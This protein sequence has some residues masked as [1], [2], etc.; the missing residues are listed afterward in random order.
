[1]SDVSVSS[2]PKESSGISQALAA[3]RLGV[4]AV[5]FFVMSAAAPLTVIGGVVTSAYAT[6]ELIGMPVAFLAIG[7]VLALFSVGYVTM[8]KYVANAG[9]FYAYVSRGLG[10][11]FGVAA[12]WVALVAYNT[13][14]VAL[15]GI[16]GAA[17]SPLFE[18]W[19]GVTVPWWVV[20][21]AAWLFVGVLG[22]QQVDVNGKVLAAL[23]VT[24]IAVIV[25]YSA[26]DFANPA[27]GVVDFAPLNPGALFAPGVGALFAIGVL[28]FIG[29][30]SSVVFSEE[31]RDPDRTVRVAT[32]ASVGLIALLYA[33][34]AWAM[35]VPMGSANVVAASKKHGPD[36]IFHLAGQHLGGAV[37]TIGHVL[38]VTSIVAAMIS[39]H[40]TTARY[41]YALGRE[42]VLPPV[43]ARTSGRTGSPKGGSLFQSLVGFVVI[44]GFII[45]TD[46]DPVVNLFFWGGT[47]GAVGV[48]LLLAGTAI[49]ILAFFLRR[50]EG[51]QVDSVWRRFVAPSL[52]IVALTFISV[53]AIVN[54]PTL[55]GVPPT[56]PLRWVVPVTFAVV[57]IL[58]FGWAM[59][60][61][62]IRPG[63]YH[64]IGLGA[65]SV[66]DDSAPRH[67]SGR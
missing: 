14:Q 32:Y 18:Q 47:S 40:N 29:F 52:S 22:L 61:R 13:L 17:A 49:A 48:L 59:T 44:V 56:A 64:A 35:S 3:G 65:R 21:L 41:A 16:I 9:A 8:A 33:F 4:P 53:L 19:F 34:S 27:N 60:L 42:R 51:T 55:L 50:P 7:L 12:A 24:E 43:L 67:G 11:P 26:A 30:E 58:G 25:V 62:S 39:F 2:A 57:A 28:G 63:V 1:M 15:Y 38:F 10:R 6:T 45:Q 46:A 37:V 23:L 20:A 36:L 54:L 5:V 31:S 66:V